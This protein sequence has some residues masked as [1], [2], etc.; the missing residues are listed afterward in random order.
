M[1]SEQIQVLSE[2]QKTKETPGWH[3]LIRDYSARC[4]ILQE[5]INQIGGN[6]VLYSENDIRKVEMRLIKEIIGYEEALAQSMT[7]RSVGDDLE[8]Y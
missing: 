4:G 2:I 3:H 6:D 8:S 1:T 5:T 7:A